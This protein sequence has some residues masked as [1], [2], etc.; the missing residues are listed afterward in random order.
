MMPNLVTVVLYVRDR[1]L[2]A[3][4]NFKVRTYPK[5]R[6]QAT[7]IR[8]TNTAGTISFL[9]S[10]NSD[11]GID[12]LNPD[13]NYEH[14]CFINSKN[15]NTQPIIIGVGVGYKE[16]D[17]SSETSS[18]I[19]FYAKV[20]D[21]NGKPMANFPL[22]TAYK[23]SN[24]ESDV[25]YTDKT[26]LVELYSSPNRTVDIKPLTPDDTF[27]VHS[28]YEITTSNTYDI[29]LNN[30]LEK[31]R[32]KVT[33][34]LFDKEGNKKYPNAKF[35]LT[36]KHYLFEETIYQDT[37]KDSTFTISSFIGDEL[38]IN[39][40]RPS[41]T[42]LKEFNLVIT[43]MKHDITVKV[44]VH[45]VMTETRESEPEEDVD[46]II[47]CSCNKNITYNQIK[48][49]CPNAKNTLLKKLVP[50][51]NNT[52][53]VYQINTC[54]RKSHFL[55]QICHESGEFKYRA[56]ILSDAKAKSHYGGYKGRGF[57]QLTFK[58]AYKA[59]GD[60]KGINFLG[61]NKTKLEQDKYAIDS[62]GWFWTEFKWKNLNDLANANDIIGISSIVNGG[63]NGFNERVKY[64]KK[65]LAVLNGQDCKNLSTEEK[66]TILV[67]NFPDSIVYRQMVGESFGWGLWHDSNY[68]KKGCVKHNI[69]AKE[70]YENFLRLDNIGKKF[71]PKKRYG[72][73]QGNAKKQALKRLRSL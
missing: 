23:N 18:L 33:L 31:Y 57:M 51:L 56:E 48:E 2:K 58:S 53:K 1:N 22:K 20:T 62:A 38:G 6:P 17:Y 15:G 21:S 36:S 5:S 32:S 73:T 29:K 3:L 25:K 72:Y 52:F 45:I 39:I 28:S 63:F 26:G 60:Y 66:N 8:T 24:R 16:E 59:Y 43:R 67:F 50:H 13:N 11:I 54:L 10:P 55:A 42:L 46:L 49:I 64:F 19:T 69:V 70:G 4:A 37:N 68:N 9:A 40:F 34:R 71:K 47:I 41:G 7:M 14:N 61:A 30:P 65:S 12:I 27:N 35:R 44:P